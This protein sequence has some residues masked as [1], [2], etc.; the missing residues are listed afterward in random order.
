MYWSIFWASNLVLF[1]VSACI[2]IAKKEYRRKKGAE[3]E[4]C[5][6]FLLGE[7]ASS[8]VQELKIDTVCKG[9]DECIEFVIAG[10]PLVVCSLCGNVWSNSL[11]RS[12][13]NQAA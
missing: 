3:R 13:S 5:R 11:P 1:V 8:E 10:S 4:I 9:C 12:Q 2:W 6:D 7:I